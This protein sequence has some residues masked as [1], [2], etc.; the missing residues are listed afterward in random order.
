MKKKKKTVI[1]NMNY[2]ETMNF[3]NEIEIGEFCE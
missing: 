3:V 2:I 1:E